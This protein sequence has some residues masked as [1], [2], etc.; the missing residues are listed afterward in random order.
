MVTFTTC[1]NFDAF[2][3]TVFQF[4][5]KNSILWLGFTVRTLD[6]E[7]LVMIHVHVDRR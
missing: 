6:C 2:Y 7:Q 3:M 4:V 1:M 5:T